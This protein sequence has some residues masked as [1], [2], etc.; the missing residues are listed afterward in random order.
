MKSPKQGE[1][2]LTST[3]RRTEILLDDIYVR[4]GGEFREAVVHRFVDGSGV[5]FDR[6]L[7]SLIGWE[8]VS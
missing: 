8:R 4:E 1:V 2:W 6:S 7:R 5:V 3:G